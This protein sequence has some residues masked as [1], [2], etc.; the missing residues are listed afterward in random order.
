MNYYV[1]KIKEYNKPL[2]EFFV[3]VVASIIETNYLKKILNY[4]YL[5][6]VLLYC[7][8]FKS[9]PRYAYEQQCCLVIVSEFFNKIKQLN[10]LIIIASSW[11]LLLDFMCGHQKYRQNSQLAVTANQVN[12]YFSCLSSI[13]LSVVFITSGKG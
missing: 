11:R 10:N 1:V 3:F 6:N 9:F 2:K 7:K 12:H 4:F 5:C 13:Y 8:Y